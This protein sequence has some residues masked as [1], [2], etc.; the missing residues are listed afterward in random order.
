MMS[1]GDADYYDEYDSDET[2]CEGVLKTGYL[3]KQGK[4]V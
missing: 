1:S 4:L 2:S 3:Y